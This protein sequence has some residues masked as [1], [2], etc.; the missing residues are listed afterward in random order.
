[1]NVSNNFTQLTERFLESG[2]LEHHKSSR[3]TLRHL[4]YFFHSK[5]STDPLQKHLLTYQ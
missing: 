4:N 3:N 5:T 1:M 2:A